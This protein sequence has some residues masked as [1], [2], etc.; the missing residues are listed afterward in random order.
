MDR[1]HAGEQLGAGQE[2]ISVH[3]GHDGWFRFALFSDGS[4]GVIRTQLNSAVWTP[5][6]VPQGGGKLV[7][8]SDGN[9]VA[10]TSTNVP[11]WA[12]NT[13]GHPGAWVVM[14]NDGNLVVYDSQ[15][16]PLWAS[17]SVQNL[18]SPTINYWDS[19]YNFDETSESWKELCQSFPCFLALQWPGYATGICEDKID[20]E[21][22]VIQWWKGWCPRFL[23]FVG[24]KTFPG[25]VGGEVGIYRRIPGKVRPTSLPSIVPK[26]LADKFLSALANLADNDL[27]WP[28]PELGARVEFTMM[29][30]VNGRKLC[31]A[32]PQKTYWLTKW[33]DD[34]SYSQYQRDQGPLQWSWLPPGTPGNSQTPINWADYVLQFRI[35][36]KTYDSIPSGAATLRSAPKTEI[37]TVSRNKDKLDVFAVDVNGLV[38]SAAWEPAFTDGWHGVW[39]IG[40]QRFPPGAAVS[41]V[42]RSADKLDIFATNTNGA[43]LTAAW[44]PTNKDGWHGWWNVAN[45]MAAPGAAVTCVSRGVNKL[46]VFVVGTDGHV[47]TSA[48]DPAVSA[49]WS[50]WIQIGN[51][52]LPAGVP[53]HVVSR[54]TDKLDIFATDSTGVVRTAAWE[55]AF[56]D[57]WHGWWDV[58]NGR[59]APGAPVTAVSRGPNKLDIFVVGTD[60]HVWTAAWD[61]ASSPN[62]HGWISIG[63][64]LFPGG[65]AIHAVSRS[66]DKIDIFGT[67]ISGVVRTAAWEPAFRDGWHGWW[68]MAGGRAFPGAPVNAVS[69]SADKLDVFV[70]GIDGRTYTAAWEPSFSGWH[71][72]WAI[73]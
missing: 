36:G 22:V 1:L 24:V 55:P 16:T 37:A 43:V 26:P 67:D 14:Q 3:N 72:W 25:G 57:G 40:A 10:Y 15:N 31:S 7:M 66:L 4:F 23:G 20:G 54:A 32:G 47:F 27:W 71:G 53:I 50:S 18:S 49:N 29:N 41:A 5:P 61:H 21:P 58:L 2:L 68:E 8:Q 19:G 9:F 35:N 52:K 42:S 69:R 60:G 59:A 30:P 44:E 63:S 13:A 65:A 33:M 62:W 46:D 28:F 56:T 12:S 48:W 51:V 34:D 6:I 11:Y 39:Q 17:N 73:D 64:A 38:Q 45:G 70:I